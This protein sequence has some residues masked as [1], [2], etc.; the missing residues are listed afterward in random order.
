MGSHLTDEWWE[1]KEKQGGY[2]LSG[3]PRDELIHHLRNLY[4]EKKELL[5]DLFLPTSEICS[6]RGIQSCHQ[7]E[8]A[9]CDDNQTPSIKRLKELIKNVRSYNL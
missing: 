3:I 9:D 8:K 4:S 1:D 7:C 6:K 2:F 5:A